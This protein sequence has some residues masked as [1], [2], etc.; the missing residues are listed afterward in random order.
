MIKYLSSFDTS[1]KYALESKKEELEKDIYD[2]GY[3]SNI[4][5]FNNYNISNNF[6]KLKN[7]ANF[8]LFNMNIYFRT[9]VHPSLL[10]FL[11]DSIY[12]HS[13]LYHI[14]SLLFPF[15]SSTPLHQSIQAQTS[16]HKSPFYW[17]WEWIFN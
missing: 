13:S 10:L 2:R 8:R 15:S 3:N 7:Y 9:N 5:G 11:C 6:K 4:S 17:R 1:I 12:Y 16:Y 14:V